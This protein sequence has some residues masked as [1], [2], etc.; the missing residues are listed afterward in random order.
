MISRYRRSRFSHVRENHLRRK[1]QRRLWEIFMQLCLL[2]LSSFLFLP[3]PIWQARTSFYIFNVALPRLPSPPFL[4]SSFLETACCRN[5]CTLADFHAGDGHCCGL[6]KVNPRL[7]NV[8]IVSTDFFRW[9]ISF[10]IKLI[11]SRKLCF[12][13]SFGEVVM[14]QMSRNHICMMVDEK[15]S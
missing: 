9:I 3:A 11:C 4:S 7:S 15:A 6:I 12:D 8:Q 10:Y 5:D 2:G 1:P 13:Y 14:L